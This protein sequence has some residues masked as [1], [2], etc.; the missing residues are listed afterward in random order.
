MSQNFA[1]RL[2]QIRESRDLSQQEL[3]EKSGLQST[4]ISHFETG[5]R[6]PSFDNLKRLADA[7]DV[8]T[9]YLLG[10]EEA[11]LAGPV[12]ASLFRDVEK[13]TSEDIEMLKM[14][15]EAMLKKRGEA[16]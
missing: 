1:G 5:A 14:M 6:S 8:N 2:K 4:A 15:K 7:L 13:L 3:A 9:D 16:S 10:R 11:S 12:A